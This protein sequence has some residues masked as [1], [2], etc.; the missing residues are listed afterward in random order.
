MGI[1]DFK[2]KVAAKIEQFFDYIIRYPR[3][4]IEFILALTVFTIA[5]YTMVPNEWYASRSIYGADSAK[6]IVGA[7]LLWPSA[8]MLYWRIRH[9]VEKYVYKFQK[10]RRAKLFFF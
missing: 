6:F 2:N 7:L 1:G 10:K 5:I 8:P 3:E 9:G 4:S